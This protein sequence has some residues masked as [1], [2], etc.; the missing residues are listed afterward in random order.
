MMTSNTMNIAMS[1]SNEV[2]DPELLQIN[3][4]ISTSLSSFSSGYDGNDLISFGDG[5]R[6]CATELSSRPSSALS[7][8]SDELPASSSSNSSNTKKSKGDSIYVMISNTSFAVP[9]DTYQKMKKLNWLTDREGVRHLNTSPAIFEVLLSHIVFESLPAYDTLSKNEYNEFEPL[10]L[11]LELYDLIEH[12]GRSS[13]KTL[14][15][16]RRHDQQLVSTRKER[17]RSMLDMP[18][19]KQPKERKGKPIVLNKENTSMTSVKLMAVNNKCARLFA[20]VKRKG[21]AKLGT[22]CVKSTHAELC[23]SDHIN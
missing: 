7:F 5:N 16:R 17:R 14:R 2:L 6:T 8:L 11:S 21:V 13:D 23:A 22:R 4:D 1:N 15:R 18:R 3:R 9:R 12:F 19:K 10:A 20:S